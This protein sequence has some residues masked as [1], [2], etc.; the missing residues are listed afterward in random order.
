MTLSTCFFCA[1]NLH[2]SCTEIESCACSLQ[3][4]NTELVLS[5]TKSE[6]L[7]SESVS[8]PDDEDE[9]VRY[10]SRSK[11]QSNSRAS[12]RASSLKDQQSTGRKRAA[13]LYPLDREAACEWRGKSNVGG[14]DYPIRGCIYGKQEARHHGPIKDTTVNDEGNVHRICHYCHNR[15]HVVNDPGYNW[16]R[17]NYPSHRPVD[18]TE[19]ER[20]DAIIDEMRYLG[21]KQSKLKI[22]D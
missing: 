21:S 13:K 22:V 9:G 17:S 6:G 2:E 5:P 4:H 20:E 3:S 10:K 12:K 1:A 16:N 18:M 8:E 14:G 7:D 15:W 19:R 11:R